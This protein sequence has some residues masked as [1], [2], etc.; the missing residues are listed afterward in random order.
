M[1][2]AERCQAQLIILRVLEPL[3]EKLSLQGPGLDFAEELTSNIVQDYF[4]NL[5]KDIQEKGINAE[6]V[7]I[8]GRPQI[9]ILRYAE[10]ENVDLIV[11]TTRGESGISRWLRGSI[12]DRVAR[13]SQI[14]VL[15]IPVHQE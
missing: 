13:G 9:E 14:P 6:A 12:A 4:D 1:A 10:T 5:I 8:S 11:F 3:V 2:L 15:I 7:I